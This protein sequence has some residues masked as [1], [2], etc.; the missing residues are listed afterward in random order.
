MNQQQ[1]K[2]EKLKR[3]KRRTSRRFPSEPWLP[4][5]YQGLKTDYPYRAMREVIR[6]IQIN[7]TQETKE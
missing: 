6:H 2:E 4:K 3:R 5:E 1:R 7:Q